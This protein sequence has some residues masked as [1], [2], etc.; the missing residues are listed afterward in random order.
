M[1]TKISGEVRASISYPENN[2][3]VFLLQCKAQVSVYE[4]PVPG[5]S[6]IRNRQCRREGEKS[7]TNYRGSA[8]RKGARLCCVDFCLSR[9][10][11]YLSIVVQINPFRPNSSHTTT[12]S[13]SSQFSAKIFSWSA[14][15]GGP[16]KFFT[17]ARTHFL[18]P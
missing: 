1:F 17:G 16:K 18:P 10:Y 4:E 8:V 7:G 12:E 15:V 5:T 2:I 9:H 3:H 13:Q 14:D 6:R 11:Q